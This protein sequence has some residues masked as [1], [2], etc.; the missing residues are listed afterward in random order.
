[1]NLSTNPLFLTFAQLGVTLPPE[2]EELFEDCISTSGLTEEQQIKLADYCSLR[3][4]RNSCTSIPFATGGSIVEA[5][6]LICQRAHEA[7]N[8]KQVDGQ[9]LFMQG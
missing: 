8:L 4:A 9:W 2:W 7:G 6:D 1:M 3:I 5:A